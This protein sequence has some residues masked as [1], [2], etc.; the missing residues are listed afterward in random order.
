MTLARAATV[1]LIAAGFLALFPAPLDAHAN[2]PKAPAKKVPGKPTKPKLPPTA[3]PFKVSVRHT[4][5]MKSRAANQVIARR[6]VLTLRAQGFTASSAKDRYSK[7]YIVTARMM[8]WR[9]V[10][11]AP[12]AAMANMAANSYRMRGFQARVTH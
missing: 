7:T 11:V 9:Q 4:A 3:K 8:R 12:N 1:A 6:M 5:P 2:P 10:A